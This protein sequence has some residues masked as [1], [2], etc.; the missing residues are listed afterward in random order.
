[1]TR[2]VTT[3]QGVDTLGVDT[4]VDSKTLLRSELRSEKLFFIGGI[5]FIT[6]IL[7]NDT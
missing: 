3:K 5:S 4:G 1:V 2:Q 7:R 6:A